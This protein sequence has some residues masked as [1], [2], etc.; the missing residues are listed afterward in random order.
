MTILAS[1][2]AAVPPAL[3]LPVTPAFSSTTATAIGWLGSSANPVNH[4]WGALT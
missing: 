1:G 4:A 2:A 3:S